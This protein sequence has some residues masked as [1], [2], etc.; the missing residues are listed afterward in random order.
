MRATLPATPSARAADLSSVRHD[1]RL[2]HEP[3]ALV[4]PKGARRVLG[5]DGQRRLRHATL[6]QEAQVAPDQR[7]RDAAS[8]PR[9]P[10]EDLLGVAALPAERLVLGL[11]DEA[12][13]ATDDLVALP[14]DLPDLELSAQRVLERVQHLLVGEA[15]PCSVVAERLVDGLRD[16]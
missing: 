13:H 8:A 2:L 3:E 14:G 15:R 9:A 4:E 16:R 12:E 7:T 1:P 11:I 6:A 5:V 10:R